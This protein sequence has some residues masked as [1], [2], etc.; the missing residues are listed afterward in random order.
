MEEKR[1]TLVHDRFGVACECCGFV[2][3]HLCKQAALYAA[4]R[5]KARHTEPDNWVSVWDSMAHKGAT[6]ETLV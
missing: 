3:G 1:V 5:H 4:K 2:S 6:Q